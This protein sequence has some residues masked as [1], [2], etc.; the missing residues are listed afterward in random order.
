MTSSDVQ[1]PSIQI[2][3]LQMCEN[4]FG[5]HQNMEFRRATITMTVVTQGC[6]TITLAEPANG[7]L[8]VRGD[9]VILIVSSRPGCT[10]SD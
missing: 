4:K 7:I 3:A 10:G 6:N 8:S 5:T 1:D 9:L 2:P